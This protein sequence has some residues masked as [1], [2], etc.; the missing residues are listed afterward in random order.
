MGNRKS[1]GPA[2]RVLA[3][4]VVACLIAAACGPAT[5]SGPA[6]R[7]P[8]C[9]VGVSWNNYA[10]ESIT[11]GYEPAIKRPIEAAGG[12]YEMADAKSSPDAQRSQIDEF[13]A[14]GAKVIIVRA[15]GEGEARSRPRPSGRSTGPLTKASPSSPSTTSSTAQGSPGQIR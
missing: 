11:A 4:G 15:Q 13:V 7:A 5:A 10:E 12:R 14:K 1:G 6:S 9:L 8:G 2:A 3:I